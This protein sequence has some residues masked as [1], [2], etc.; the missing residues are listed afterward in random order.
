MD[1]SI[2][3]RVDP[4]GMAT[5]YGNA[6]SELGECVERAFSEL[7]AKVRS[8]DIKEILR[9]IAGITASL[10][11]VELGSLWV[12]RT[13]GLIQVAMSFSVLPVRVEVSADE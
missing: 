5:T 2:T 8:G 7:R 1:Q 10:Q 11:G 4:L 9:Y 12:T 3:V 13:D 6:N